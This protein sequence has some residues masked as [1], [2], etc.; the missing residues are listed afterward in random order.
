MISKLLANASQSRLKTALVLAAFAFLL[1]SPALYLSQIVGHSSALNVNWAEGFAQQIMEGKLYPRWLPNMTSGAGSPVFYFY[2]PLPFYV[3]TPFVLITGQSSIAIVCTSLTLLFCSGFACFALCR[4]YASPYNALIA[5]L[6]YIV[7]PYHFA[8]DIWMRAALGEQAAFIF[9][10]LTALCILKI[11]QNARYVFALA[12]SFAGLIFSHIPSTLLYSPVL[13]FLT[14]WIAWQSRSQ[15]IIWKSVLGAVLGSGLS[16]I[17]IIPAY[18]LQTMIKAS[19]WYQQLPEENLFVTAEMATKFGIFIYPFL[20]IGALFLALSTIGL[21]NKNVAQNTKPW[22]IIGMTV[23]VMTSTIAIPLW[24]HAGFFRIIQFP[25]RA[26]AILDLCFAVMWANLWQTNSKGRE[27]L[28]MFTRVMIIFT[29]FMAIKYQYQIYQA[30]SDPY[31]MNIIDEQRDLKLKTDGAEYLPA[32]Y[33]FKEGERDKLITRDYAERNLRAVKV[34]GQLNIN[35]FPFLI[36]QMGSIQVPIIC[37]L[38]TGFIKY[39]AAAYPLPVIVAPQFLPIE[40]IA[41]K[42]SLVS[43]LMLIALAFLGKFWKRNEKPQ[44]VRNSPQLNHT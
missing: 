42:I 34:P 28:A 32:C 22:I 27:T 8:T 31:I 38:Q 17:Y 3:A 43:L 19:N 6:I 44:C 9:M 36:A 10:P 12:L 13:V 5:S 11:N 14:F 30:P 29:L 26:L 7:L 41:A 25:W 20:A 15:L 18:S 24:Q 37:D 39:D 35:Y 40:K 16:A 4:C 23:L 2:G 21:R 33:Q 1:M